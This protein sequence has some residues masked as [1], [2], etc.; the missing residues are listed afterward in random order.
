MSL[1][2]SLV[3]ATLLAALSTPA[4]AAEEVTLGVTTWTGA[5]AIAHL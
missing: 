5:Q 1:K 4:F 3:T 2:K